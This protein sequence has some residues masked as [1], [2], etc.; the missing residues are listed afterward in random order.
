MHNFQPIK[1]KASQSKGVNMDNQ[2]ED[3]SK[4]LL[5]NA[6]TK[7]VI[8][9]IKQSSSKHLHVLGLK[10][11]SFEYLID[12]YGDQFTRIDFDKCPLVN[13]LSKLSK[14]GN[15]ESISYYWNQRAERLWDMSS[16]KKLKS[17][18][19]IDFTRIHQLDDLTTSNH[20]EDI[21]FGNEIWSTWILNTLKPIADVKNLKKL[22]FSAKKIEDF[23]ITPLSKIKNLEEINFPLNL[24][25][26]EKIAWLKARVGDDVKS[27]VL[28]PL[29]VRERPINTGKKNIDTY[30]IGKRKPSLDSSIDS[31]RIEKY[32]MKFNNLVEY[33]KNNPDEKEPV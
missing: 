30:I 1:F 8:D 33:Y 32:I 16:N 22:W 25:T 3:P 15:I 4:L 27:R 17:L 9:N 2:K 23:R 5:S 7:D 19:L 6:E 29:M 11:D 28:A 20:L 31:A 14:L 24:F 10:Q 21:E 12:T 26:T 18:K 13:D